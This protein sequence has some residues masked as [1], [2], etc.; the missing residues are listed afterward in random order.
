VKILPNGRIAEN[1]REVSAIGKRIKKQIILIL[2]KV[3]APR[4][5]SSIR[6]ERKNIAAGEE[7][8]IVVG[9]WG[10]EVIVKKYPTFLL[11]KSGLHSTRLKGTSSSI[12]GRK[13][14]K[15]SIGGILL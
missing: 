8:K 4:K 13:N 2:R 12:N 14:R 9:V 6:D 11:A 15:R 1:G 7:Q 5:G 3:I 10:D